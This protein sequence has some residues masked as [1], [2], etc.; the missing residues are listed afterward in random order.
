M[1][2]TVS[3]S[4]PRH[5]GSNRTRAKNRLTAV[6]VNVPSLTETYRADR[7]LVPA[8]VKAQNK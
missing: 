6:I 3:I 1:V 8:S 5:S 4:L 2:R 7:T